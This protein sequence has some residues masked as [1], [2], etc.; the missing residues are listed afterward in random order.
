MKK[1]LCYGDSNTYGYIPETFGRYTKNERWTGILSELLSP[2]YEILEQGMNNRTGF[3]KNP[4]NIK[5][6]GGEYLPIYLQNHKDIDICILALGTNDSQY[7]Y[8]L[9]KNSATAGLKHLIQS[10]REA[11]SK[12]K[13]LIIPPVKIQKN[14]LDGIFAMQFD[15]N[16]VEKIKNV[17]PI[18]KKVS[19]EMNCF[20]LDLNE[21]VT[22]SPVDGLHYSKE[23]HKIIA[24]ILANF[25]KTNI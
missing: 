7:F 2:E 19:E 20:Y 22:P 11:N 10:I 3:F 1:I 12:T 23:S 21:F 18:F 15:L 9:D 5:L 14:I 25:I 8:N 6:C 17:F 16:S 4:E 24:Q 13:I